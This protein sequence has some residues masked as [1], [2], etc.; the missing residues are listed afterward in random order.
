MRASPDPRVPS[1][2]AE[3]T[4]SRPAAMWTS[5]VVH[6]ARSGVAAPELD[7]DAVHLPGEETGDAGVIESRDRARPVRRLTSDG[8]SCR[9]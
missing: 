6:L 5:A 1:T 7:A 9:R 2:A 3:S 4:P 8:R